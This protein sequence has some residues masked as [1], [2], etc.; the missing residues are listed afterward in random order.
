[1]K[2]LYLLFIIC[3]LS[4]SPAGAQV[5]DS[6]TPLHLMKPAY[7]VGY[8]VSK[9]EEVKQVMDRVLQYIGSVTP[10][11]LVDS[12]TGQ[13]IADLKKHGFGYSTSN[14]GFCAATELVDKQQ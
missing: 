7:K 6:N 10:A 2:R 12:K 8:G 14:S 1:M 9:P 11:R 13:P 3:Y 5:N 4:F